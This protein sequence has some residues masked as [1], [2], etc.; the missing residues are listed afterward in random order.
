[1]TSPLAHGLFGLVIVAALSLLFV[2]GLR[3]PA[4]AP[5][6]PRWAARVGAV[7]GGLAAV[8]LANVALYRHD[9]HFDLTASRAFTL[10]PEVEQLARSLRQDVE[11]IYFYQKQDPAGRAAKTL[12]E[13]MGRTH[14]RLHVR[15]V[16]PDQSPALASRY[17]VSTYN[18]AVLESEGRRMQ[19]VSTS[20][21]DIAL[22]IVR[23][24]R[25]E[26]KT[27]CFAVGH[28]E[29]DIANMEYHTHFEG[30]HDHGHGAEGAAVV[31]MEQHGLGRLR[32]ALESL[33]LGT[34]KVTL[35][36]AGGVPPECSALVD[37]APRTGWAP[38]E[39]DALARYLAGGGAAMLLYD[40]D[41]PV[42]PRQAGLL[43]GLGLRLGDGAVVDP[44]DHYFTDEQMVAVTRYAAH[45]TT[46]GLSLTFF[47]GVRPIELLPP[48]PGLTVTPLFSSS[49]GSHLQRLRE[50]PRAARATPP[51]APAVLAAAVEGPWPGAAGGKPFRLL[52]VGDAD[53][54]SNSFFPY[55]SNA[56]LTLAG[57]A[58]L[59]REERAPT[60]KPPVEVLPRVVLTA[61][62]VRGIFLYTVGVLPGLAVVAGGALWWRRRR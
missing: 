24:T 11:L 7:A 10:A 55:M 12:V 22:G 15:T 56:D 1:M 42:E 50:P 2:A 44:T 60:M 6:W 46:E 31:L 23:V 13:I 52:L 37:A 47:P 41:F 62:Q 43:A 49:A 38:P 33:G 27:V 39:T 35:A 5:G 61:R 3:L 40:L 32:R 45:P 17:G 16:D 18:V 29:Y 9:L 57:L 58:W 21:R 53:F 4:G 20:D 19:V 25:L 28:G 48:P 51:R 8:V 54:A 30:V 26:P 14:P 59:L 34:R 36:L